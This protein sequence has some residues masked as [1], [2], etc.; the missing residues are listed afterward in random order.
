MNDIY[1]YC[2]L[3]LGYKLFVCGLY[4]DPSVTVFYV[5]WVLCY[6]VS[7]SRNLWIKHLWLG[8]CAV[9]VQVC[10]GSLMSQAYTSLL[11]SWCP[12]SRLLCRMTTLD[13]CVAGQAAAGRCSQP[14]CCVWQF[15]E[16]PA[17]WPCSCCIV[18]P[19]AKG[20]SN[21]FTLPQ[22]RDLSGG[23][24]GNVALAWLDSLTERLW[25]PLG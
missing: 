19:S 17:V 13:S 2:Y 11:A 10:Y 9:R 25:L 14:H 4:S 22:K 8:I 5:S 24:L 20:L 7:M 12:H 3:L 16:E 21:A 23:C 6:Y 15:V 18:Y 1:I